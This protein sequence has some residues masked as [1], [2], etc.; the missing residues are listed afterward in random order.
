MTAHRVPFVASAG[1]GTVHGGRSFGGPPPPPRVP[2]TVTI[3]P[4]PPVSAGSLPPAAAPLDLG[5]L[6]PYLTDSR[7]TDL[8][9]NGAA[10]LWLDRGDGLVRATSWPALGEPAVRQLAV[11]LIAQGGRHVDEATPCVDARLPGGVRVHVVLPPLSTVGTLIS[12][13]IPRLHPLSLA[14][15][16]RCGMLRTGQ[17]TA[18]TVAVQRRANLLVS[19]PAGSGKTTLLAALLASA[20]PAERIVTVEDVAELRIDHPHVVSLEARQP[21]TEG[22]GAVRLDRL[23]REAL[24]M[25]PDRLVVGECRGAE[26]RELLTALNTGSRGGAG[27]VHANSLADVSARLEALGALAGLGARALGRQ[28]VSAI[29]VVLHLENGPDGR[30]LAEAGELFLD[31]SGRLHTRVVMLGRGQGV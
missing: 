12:V 23:V 24:R 11:R 13:R 19:G 31:R 27:T 2:R 21:N 7:I 10:G 3:R 22:A 28:V 8:L 14:D 9:V 16:E 5:P 26:I 30:R 1:L 15:L 25:R 29:H 6:T 17:G 18:L 20:S 4:E